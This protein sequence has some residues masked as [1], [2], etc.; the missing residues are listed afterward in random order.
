ML[1][2]DPGNAAARGEKPYPDGW[3]KL[4]KERIGHVHCKDVVPAG[5]DKAGQDKTEWAAMGAGII[6]WVGQFRALKAAGYQGALSLETHWR[7]AGS[8]E[9]STRKSMAGLKE[10]LQRAEQT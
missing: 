9:A 3:A 2:W 4:P 8:A 5:K 10:L 1:N 6:D 7:G